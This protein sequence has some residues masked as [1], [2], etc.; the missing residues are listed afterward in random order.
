MT[1]SWQQRKQR[2]QLRLEELFRNWRGI[3]PPMSQADVEARV[4]AAQ[5]DGKDVDIG[6]FKNLHVVVTKNGRAA[7]W[8]KFTPKPPMVPRSIAIAAEYFKQR[9]MKIR[10]AAYSKDRSSAGVLTYDLAI[11]KVMQLQDL[12][13]T[14][15][16]LMPDLD[17][18]HMV[19]LALRGGAPAEIAAS[20][21]ERTCAQILGQ[22]RNWLP[23]PIVGG[24]IDES[25]IIEAPDPATVSDAEKDIGPLMGAD[26]DEDDEHTNLGFDVI[27]KVRQTDDGVEITI[28]GFG[29]D[30]RKKH[31]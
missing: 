10:L 16:R 28:P 15:R 9:P 30:G 7:W 26:P 11:E 5:C 22:I 17:E 12:L 4:L 25:E 3:D 8:L 18:R 19:E 2:E 1:A 13:A 24:D 20:D 27:G 14:A 31:D 6:V 21:N 23:P 29:G